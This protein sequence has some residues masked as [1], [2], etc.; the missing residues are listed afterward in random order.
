MKKIYKLYPECKDYV[1]GGEKLKEKYGKRTGKTL[2]AESWELSFHKDGL[3]RL[4]NGKTL[5][6]SITEQE[7]GEKAKR[8]PFFPV[9]NKFIDAKEN[10]SVQVHPSDDYA[11]T[12]E[13][14]FGKTEMWYIVEAEAGA[15]IY[16]GFK[17]D[18]SEA[19]YK[20]AI[21]D[22]RLTELLNFY[23]V[24]AGE[25]YFIP[26][27]TIHAIGKGCLIYEIQQ[28]S[29]L[30]Y[31]VYD[32]GRLGNDGKPRE[33]HIDKALKVTDLHKFEPKT[34]DDGVL[35]ESEYFT[36]KK[37]NVRG[38]CALNVNEDSFACYTCVKGAG[39]LA[40]GAVCLGDSF[41]V[42]AGFG[43][44][45]ATGNMELIETKI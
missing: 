28:N 20:Q 1:W 26:S 29:N 23:E 14:S 43:T 13:N 25:S 24:K 36:V 19:E 40:G 34:F 9:L 2:C 3:T 16:L 12:H 6:E 15:G 31:R 41:F 33:L 21:E 37:M 8:F 30:T 39:E 4:V 35:G 27:G 45:E 42:P 5:A 18:V 10:L 44:L 7:L 32:Y 38:R 11:L 17:R 22:N